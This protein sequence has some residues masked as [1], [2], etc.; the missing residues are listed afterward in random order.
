M[1]GELAR[2]DRSI[3][4]AIGF[5]ESRQTT[6]D[7]IRA[8]GAVGLP[9]V[10]GTLSA[11]ELANNQ[12]YFQVSPQDRREAEVAAAY[13]A[14]R[15]KPGV[16]QSGRQLTKRVRIYLSDDPEDIYSK[17]LA[18][19]AGKSFGR[20]GFA[21]EKV[22]F[23]PSDKNPSKPDGRSVADS[24]EAG[25]EA[26]GFDDVAFYAGRS[27]PDFQGFLGGVS[28][29]CKNSPPF[30][31]ADDD[32]TDYVADESI[33]ASNTVPFKYISFAVS[34]EIADKVENRAKDFYNLLNSMF[35]EVA[36]KGRSLDGHAALTYDA[37]YSAITA[38]GYLATG[39]EKIPVTGG[40]L[41][42]ALASI[43]NN[44]GKFRQY[45]GVT[46]AIDFGGVVSRRF[47]L[48]KPINVLQVEDGIPN[49]KERAFCGSPNDPATQT[50][51]PFDP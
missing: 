5:D 15:L 6:V 30:V 16:P 20:Q 41:W 18:D 26:C 47:P 25:H 40:T 8:L 43:T 23:T 45:D 38:A 19:D 48:N 2:L 22:Q 7:M 33:R 50:W 11:D 29:G 13:A 9:V 39:S 28:D 37:A 24:K 51:C 17:N 14:Q 32:V 35:P 46:G 12:M 36:G 10:A 44:Q 21:V 1:L 42:W 34:P 4:A 49:V 27:L 3:V 31:I